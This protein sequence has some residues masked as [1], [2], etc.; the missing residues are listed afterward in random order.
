MEA[1]A[2]VE[3][4]ELEPLEVAVPL[5][6][7]APEEPAVRLAEAVLVLELRLPAADVPTLA[8][9]LTAGIRVVLRPSG[10]PGAL[11]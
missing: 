8:D 4:G 3:S 10:T 2:P 11:E 6:L 1:A 7:A 9:E 5:P